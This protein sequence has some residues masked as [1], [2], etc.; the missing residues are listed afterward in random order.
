[1]EFTGERF[2]LGKSSATMEA[3]HLA[4]YN[5]ACRFVNGK[6]VLDIACGTGYGADLLA[7]A[8]ADH[9]DGVDLSEEAIAYCKSRYI[10]EHLHFMNGN[11]CDFNSVKKYDVIV[12]FETIE[13][14]EDYSK[15]LANI[16]ELLSV[17][18][19]LIIS[20][21]NRLITSPHL[22]SCNEKLKSGF[23]EREFTIPELSTACEENGFKVRDDAIYGQRLQPYFSNRIRQIIYEWFAKPK[24][25]S[26]PLVTELHGKMPRYFILVCEKLDNRLN[27][28]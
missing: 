1:M 6:R 13:H 14:V 19:I 16:F 15:A 18:G 22:K 20:S 23:H 28:P 25:R 27:R 7:S 5:F 4:R 10:R 26:S 24:K 12:S 3:D 8:G 11:I 17:G 21:P 2:V 9:V